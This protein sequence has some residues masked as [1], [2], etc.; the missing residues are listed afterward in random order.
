LQPV[1]ESSSI[2]SSSEKLKPN[3]LDGKVLSVVDSTILQ[4]VLDLLCTLLKNTD[5]ELFPN[6]FK[7]II[8][9][10]P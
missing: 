9:V 6:E 10:F 3:S 1:S 2:D 4:H 7:K 5:K 8:A